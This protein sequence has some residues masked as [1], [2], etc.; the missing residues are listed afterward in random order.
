MPTALLA[1]AKLLHAD[2]PAL[3]RVL[4]KKSYA[5]RYHA[6]SSWYVSTAVMRKSFGFC[7]RYLPVK[8]CGLYFC[9]HSVPKVMLHSEF[10]GAQDGHCL[11]SC[12]HMLVAGVRPIPQRHGAVAYTMPTVFEELGTW[13]PGT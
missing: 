11:L 7:I 6:V 12:T 1:S 13:Y 9:L 3:S 8:T 2:L 4:V 5:A 10:T